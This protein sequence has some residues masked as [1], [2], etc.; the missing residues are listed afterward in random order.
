M[1]KI[2]KLNDKELEEVVGGVAVVGAAPRSL[3]GKLVRTIV[4]LANQVG[5]HLGYYYGGGPVGKPTPL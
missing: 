2:D 5:L 4:V 3:A 1:S